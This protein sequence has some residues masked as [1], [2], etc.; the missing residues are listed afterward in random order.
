MAKQEAG[1]NIEHYC[2]FLWEFKDV[3]DC[4]CFTNIYTYM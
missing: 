2:V 1:R 3:F 4:F